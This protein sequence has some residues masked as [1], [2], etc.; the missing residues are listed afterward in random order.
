MQAA[1][2]PF[3]GWST[4]EQGHTFYIRQLWDMKASVDVDSL[5]PVELAAYAGLCGA[6]LARA[7]A[8][9]LDPALISG[10]CGGGDKLAK[11][12]SRFAEVYAD[13]NTRDHAEFA[14]AVDDGRVDALPDA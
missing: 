12:M 2:D 7:H 3:L 13:Q 9:S 8:R 10:Y 4:G 6:T 1:S 11:A 14:Q 5:S